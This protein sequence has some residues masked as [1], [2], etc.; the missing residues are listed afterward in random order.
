MSIDF[1]NAQ[2]YMKSIGLNVKVARTEQEFE[3]LIKEAATSKAEGKDNGGDLL[4]THVVSHGNLEKKDSG[5]NAKNNPNDQGFIAVSDGARG[6]NY[7]NE[8]D[9]IGDVAHAAGNFDHVVSLFSTCH[10]GSFDHE[11]AFRG[12]TEQEPNKPET[13]EPEK[14]PP[15]KNKSEDKKS[16]E[17]KNISS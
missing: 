3:A 16:D 9:F 13:N 4:L 12:N 5:S 6:S 10:S 8:K 14:K 7:Y 2:E 15:E 1:K 17:E 11:Q